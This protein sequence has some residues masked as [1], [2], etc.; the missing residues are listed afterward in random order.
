MG[1]FTKI[2]SEINL[3][4]KIF[5]KMMNIYD[6]FIFLGEGEYKFANNNYPEM[7]NKFYFLPFSVDQDFWKYEK[8][9]TLEKIKYFF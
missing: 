8:I 2:D 7:S 6:K 1:L 4:K 9:S 5:Y 3:H